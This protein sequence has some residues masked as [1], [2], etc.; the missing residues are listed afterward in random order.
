MP[1][2]LRIIWDLRLYSLGYAQRGIGAYTSAVISRLQS[3]LPDHEL[4]VIGTRKDIEQ[5]IHIHPARWISYKTGNWKTDIIAL[6]LII[7]RF[8]PDIVHHWC[9]LGP[10]YQLGI[11]PVHKAFTIATVFDL[12]VEFWQE[13]P[14]L[15]ARRASWYWR[16]QKRFIQGIQASLCISEQTRGDLQKIDHSH[17]RRI[18]VYPYLG[19]PA[20]RFPIHRETYF[21]TLA[22][23]RNKNTARTIRGFRLF[24]EA[25]SGFSLVVLGAVA[26][27]EDISSHVPESVRFESMSRYRYH[28]EHCAGLLFCSTHEGLGLP[29]LEALQLGC[30]VVASDIPVLH[31]TLGDAVVY[32]DP[33]S[34]SSIAAGMDLLAE[35]PKAWCLKASGQYRHYLGIAQ[36]QES[37]LVSLYSGRHRQQ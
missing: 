21:V 30:P 26:P 27:D 11:G 18:V 22:G 15:S 10:L 33:R 34:V 9:V 12:G 25:H 7:L 13:L 24:S 6:T 37:E 2:K 8:R 32:V 5:H 35:N 17:S 16:F 14:F 1:K 36:R 23:S 4:L 19:E 28:L 29:P 20:E 31:E 3:R